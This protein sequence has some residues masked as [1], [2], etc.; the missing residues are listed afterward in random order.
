MAKL[1]RLVL[2]VVIPNTVEVV[3]LTQELADIATM[4]GVNSLVN[5]IDKNVTNLKINLEGT[6]ISYNSVEKVIRSNGGSIHSIDNVVA[7]ES[8][9]ENVETPQD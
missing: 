7:G 5:E 3:K 9:V 6:D 4:E 8:I 2:D 1:R